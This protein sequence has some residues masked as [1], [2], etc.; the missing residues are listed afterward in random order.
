MKDVLKK[1]WGLKY[2]IIDIL[3]KILEDSINNNKCGKY[4]VNFLLNCFIYYEHQN[5]Y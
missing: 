4:Y 5:Q 1:K 2:N 3:N